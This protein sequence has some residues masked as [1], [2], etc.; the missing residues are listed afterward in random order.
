MTKAEKPNPFNNKNRR[1]N[2]SGMQESMV[3]GLTDTVEDERQ[4]L[5]NDEEEESS[6]MGNYPIEDANANFEHFES[7]N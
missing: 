2:F 6:A 7:N 4:L 1:A 5:M 3:Q